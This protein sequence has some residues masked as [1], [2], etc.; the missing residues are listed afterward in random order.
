MC[1]VSPFMA[2]F[3]DLHR[4]DKDMIYLPG[5]FFRNI[6]SNVRRF[7]TKNSQCSLHAHPSIKQQHVMLRLCCTLHL[8]NAYTCTKSV[9]TVHSARVQLASSCSK[10]LLTF[11]SACI[12]MTASSKLITQSVSGRTQAVILLN[13][14]TCLKH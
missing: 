3:S 7:D 2:R 1:L 14:S 5:Q 11:H 4:D 12:L 9:R 13:Y 8:H 10:I 6:L